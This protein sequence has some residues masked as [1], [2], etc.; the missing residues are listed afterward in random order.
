MVSPWYRGYIMAK[1]KTQYFSVNNS[2]P[3]TMSAVIEK[4]GLTAEDL[5]TLDKNEEMK[6]GVGTNGAFG[7]ISVIRLTDRE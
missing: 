4:Y 3:Q 2:K 7:T 1:Y 6:V 5:N